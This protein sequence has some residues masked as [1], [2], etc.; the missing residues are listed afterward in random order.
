MA[1]REG[2]VGG[3]TVKTLEAAENGRNVTKG[4]HWT[5]AGS[6]WAST[7]S[8]DPRRVRTTKAPTNGHARGLVVKRE[9]QDEWQCL[10][11][12]TLARS[13]TPEVAQSNGLGS[14]LPN[15]GPPW[16]MLGPVWRSHSDNMMD[17]S[18]RNLARAGHGEAAWPH[19]A[20]ERVAAALRCGVQVRPLPSALAPDDND[21]AW[22]SQEKEMEAH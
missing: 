14:E 5:R 8:L 2:R 7:A 21:D 16:V 12:D 17:A 4:H 1:A 22:P 15:A 3:R 10:S 6:S 20:V 9:Q 18:G 19:G 13:L 11:S